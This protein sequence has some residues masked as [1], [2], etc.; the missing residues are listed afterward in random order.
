MFF[1]DKRFIP[2]RLTLNLTV[3]LFMLYIDECI[4]PHVAFFCFYLFIFLFQF[5]NQHK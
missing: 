4:G 2:L 3:L 1:Y 5:I